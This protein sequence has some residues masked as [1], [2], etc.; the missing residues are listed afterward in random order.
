MFQYFLTHCGRDD[1]FGNENVCHTV[2][3]DHIRPGVSSTNRDKLI[4]DHG[5]AITSMVFH[6]VE[7][8]MCWLTPTAEKM[9]RFWGEAHD[10][11][12]IDVDL[13]PV[14]LT[15]F[16]SNSK[17]DQNLQCSCLTRTQLITTIF[18]TRHDSYTVVTCAKFRCDQWSMF[19]IRA[20]QNLIEFRI[21]SNYL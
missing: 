9:N 15:I 16:R 1:I 13:V 2:G 5:D 4:F 18:C 10:H 8:D 14:P 3:T 17:F 12:M 20:L 11:I 6:R 19:Q 7:I 21:R